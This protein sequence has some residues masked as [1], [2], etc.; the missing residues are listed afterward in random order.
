MV[1]ISVGMKKIAHSTFDVVFDVYIQ[2][3]S[4]LILSDTTNVVLMP[5]NSVDTVTFSDEFTPTLDTVYQ[6]VSYTVLT[7]D[8]NPANNTSA[9]TTSYVEEFAIWYG[10]MDGSPLEGNINSRFNIDAYVWCGEDV[11]IANLEF[12]LGAND[13]YIDS[14]LS[15]TEGQYYWPFTEWDDAEF[16]T[17]AGSPP[18]P[19]GWSSQSF[20]GFARLM[21]GS[22]APWE[23][24]N[25]ILIRQEDYF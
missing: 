11:Y 3:S 1:D 25:S 12:P 10:N 9:I 2:G 14:L 20:M 21:P 8:V 24:R 18:N 16:L 7:G 17:P 4:T 19:E 13:L 23:N 6:L 15:Q 22:T 5:G